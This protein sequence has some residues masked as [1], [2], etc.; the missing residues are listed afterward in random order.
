[1]ETV[2]LLH[3]VWPSR[4]WLSL[5]SSSLWH[6]LD[7]YIKVM[8]LH[9]V[10]VLFVWSQSFYPSVCKN[11]ALLEDIVRRLNGKKWFYTVRFQYNSLIVVTSMD[12][13]YILTF[14]FWSISCTNWWARKCSESFYHRDFGPW[15]QR[16]PSNN[17][18]AVNARGV[19]SAGFSLSWTWNQ[20]SGTLQCRVYCK[21]LLTPVSISSI[22]RKIG[23]HW[24]S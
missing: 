3:A 6:G 9:T 14:V 18:V 17:S 11:N 19:S 22:N 16:V 7:L 15:S 4:K 1:M 8:V 10:S 12:S 13:D 2:L 23:P 21:Q 24:C 5:P 20:F